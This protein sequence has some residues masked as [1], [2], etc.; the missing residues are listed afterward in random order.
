MEEKR[1]APE[2]HA[3]GGLYKRCDCARRKWLK[4]D[5]PWHFDFYKGRK[6]RFSLDVIAVARSEQPPRS[7]SDAEALADRVRS[8]IRRGTFRS[9]NQPEP[10]AP[11]PTARLTVGD[12]IDRYITRHVKSPTRRESAQKTM[13]W[14]LGVLRRTAIPAAHG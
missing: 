1:T 7:K 6:F 9:P 12:V 4:C 13:L 11:D 8:E 3:N 2:R 10:P 5:H 14:H